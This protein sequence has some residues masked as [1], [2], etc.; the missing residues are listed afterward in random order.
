MS[1][2]DLKVG[3]EAKILTL[4][5]STKINQ[6]LADLGLTSGTKIKII[7]IPP[8]RSPVKILFRQAKLA[9]GRTVAKKVLVE[10]I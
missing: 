5:G 4:I 2:T 1:I 8:F 10:L 7:T 3:Q 9:L 6:R